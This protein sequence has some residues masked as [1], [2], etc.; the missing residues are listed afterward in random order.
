MTNR[1]W[2]KLYCD[3]WLSGTLREETAE[4]RGIWADLLALAGS[5]TYGDTGRISLQNGVGFS[6][7]Q[8]VKL[9]RIT[10]YQWQKAKKR[11]ILTDRIT[12]NIENVI[13]IINWQKYQSEYERQKPYRNSKLHS[14]VTSGSY[15]GDREKDK[16]RDKREVTKIGKSWKVVNYHE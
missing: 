16:D 15:T 1:T 10:K 6:D 3:N 5:G 12:V 11:L 14:E 9:L 7:S 13:T 8:F 2:I 4:L